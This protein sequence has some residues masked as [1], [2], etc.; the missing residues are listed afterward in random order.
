[1][2]LTEQI[3][4]KIETCG[5]SQYEIAKKTGISYPA[6]NRFVTGERGMGLKTLDKLCKYLKI[7]I[8]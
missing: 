3:R 4:R 6:I 2:T 8:A 7:N 5:Q 1:M